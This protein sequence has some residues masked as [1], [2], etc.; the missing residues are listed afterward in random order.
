MGKATCKTVNFDLGTLNMEGVLRKTN[1]IGEN[2]MDMAA[3][4]KVDYSLEDSV[5][6]VLDMLDVAIDDYENGRL[7]AEEEFWRGIREE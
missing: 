5:K 4:R 3:N 7:L 6:I 2:M 1:C